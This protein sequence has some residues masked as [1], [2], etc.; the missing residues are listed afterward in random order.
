LNL[1]PTINKQFD[2]LNDMGYTENAQ[3]ASNIAFYN[4]DGGNSFTEMAKTLGDVLFT[5]ACLST[6]TMTIPN[7]LCKNETVDGSVQV[8]A[9]L[10]EI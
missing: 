7:A 1:A 5:D 6:S 9:I 8:S 10:T 3:S 4:K 2:E